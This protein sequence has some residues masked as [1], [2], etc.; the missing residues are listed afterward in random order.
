MLPISLPRR[1]DDP[2]S[3]P[4]SRRYYNAAAS[5]TRLANSYLLY[6]NKIRRLQRCLGET[7]RRTSFHLFKIPRVKPRPICSRPEEPNLNPLIQKPTSQTLFHSFRTW[8]A[9]PCFTH[10]RP[11]RAESRLTR[12]KTR[13]AESLLTRSKTRQA[14]SLLTRSRPDKPNLISPIQHLTTQTLLPCSRLDNPFFASFPKTRWPLPPSNFSKLDSSQF[15]FYSVGNL[16]EVPDGF[17]T[18]VNLLFP[19]EICWKFPKD[20]R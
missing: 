2:V 18:E 5:E 8:R 15:F 17:L 6:E 3:S 20:Y 16:L 1:Y 4:L 10:S 7:T 9:E 13:W 12:S 11:R 19:T 14:E